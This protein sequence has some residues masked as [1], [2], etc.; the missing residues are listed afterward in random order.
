MQTNHVSVP[1]TYDT[2]R[3][4]LV[5]MSGGPPPLPSRADTGEPFR[6]PVPGRWANGSGRPPQEAGVVLYLHG[7]GF[8]ERNPS[9]EHV[10]AFRL[11]EATG[12]PTFDLDYS[13]APEHPFPA[14]HDETVTAYRALLA[15]NVPAERTVLYGESAGATILL[16]ALHT[17]RA[18]D[19]PLPGAVAVVSPITDLTLTSPSIDAPAGRDA[20][21]RP[22]LERLIGQYLA[23]SPRDAAPQSPLHG[24]LAGLPRTLI[25]VGG[26]EA[27]L[28]DSRRYAE[29]AADAG[30]D[31]TLDVYEHLPHAFHMTV[32]ADQRRPVADTFLERL[33]SWLGGPVAGRS[34]TRLRADTV[35]DMT[36]LGSHAHGTDARNEGVLVYVNGELK[37]RSEAVVSVFDSGF[38]LGD[39]VW[40]GL[41]IRRG[42]P[43]F[44]DR[45]LDRLYEGAAAI[46]LDIGLSRAEL[47]EA[48]YATLRAN[49]MTDGVHV[50]L[51]V[52]RGV[53]ATPYQDPRVTVGPATVVIVAEHKEPSPAAASEGIAL[54]TVH[55]RRGAPD[56]LDPKLNAHS[57][58]N[59]IT[60]CIQAYTAGADE[61]LMLDP[62]GFVATCNSTHFFIVRHDDEGR[63]E[64]WTSSGQYCL[65]GITRGNVLRICREA[66]ITAYEKTFSLTDV[67]G[68]DEAFVTGTFAGLV[69][70]RQVDGRTIGPGTRGPTTERLQRL[71]AD[72][73]ERDVAVRAESLD[74]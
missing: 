34:G 23:G 6:M 27:L 62:N 67:Y 53:K 12:R 16:E 22:S 52:T 14:A 1:D 2:V 28:D 20:L 7:G 13:L 56:V 74:A 66:G 19:V 59:D 47:T 32:L 41:R 26:D 38:V 43:A 63:P 37:P 9:F 45:H 31:V 11:S 15:E 29:A 51:M 24:D 55:V 54:F 3:A 17:L 5:A 30:V 73:V 35:R 64:V 10:I 8:E 49:G 69:P 39:G 57:K 4:A 65:G 44:L 70:V 42:H 46:A 72:L 68:A 48:I 60:A 18:A 21:D 40:E 50:R 61:A 33:S 58:L 25:A 36:S 71:Y